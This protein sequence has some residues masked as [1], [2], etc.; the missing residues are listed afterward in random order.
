MSLKSK[1][2]NAERE[3]LHMFWGQNWAC[4]RIAG[5]GSMKYPSPDLMVG[6][7]LRRLA[8]ECKITKDSK[9]YFEKE[10]V[11]SLKTFAEIFGAEPWIAIK[12]KGFDWYFISLEDMAETGKG[13]V[14]DVDLA[15]NKGFLFEEILEK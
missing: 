11:A 2:I 3:L 7:K 12:F 8:I 1:G 14:V 6:N 15:K 9:K 13:Y 10:E 5:S 4:L